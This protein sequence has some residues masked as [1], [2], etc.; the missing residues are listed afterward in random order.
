MTH[1]YLT[2]WGPATWDIALPQEKIQ[3]LA[4]GFSPP[5]VCPEHLIRFENCQPDYRS[6]IGRLEWH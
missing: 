2:I 4:D 1:E 5:L 6:E 3:L